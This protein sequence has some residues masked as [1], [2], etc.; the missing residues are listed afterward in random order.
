MN[1]IGRRECGVAYELCIELGKARLPGVV[2]DK[3]SVNHC[4]GLVIETSA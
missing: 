4:A 2:E 3:D 1:S